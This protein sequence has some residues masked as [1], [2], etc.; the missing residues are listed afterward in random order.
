MQEYLVVVI[1]M[2][3]GCQLLGTQPQLN[4]NKTS[5]E[6]LMYVQF[7]LYNHRLFST[8]DWDILCRPGYLNV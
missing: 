8:A 7:W 5:N 1:E 3:K 2:S 6:R 4:A